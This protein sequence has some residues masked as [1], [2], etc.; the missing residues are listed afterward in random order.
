MDSD[1]MSGCVRSIQQYLK[2]DI[3]WSTHRD[4]KNSLNC[5]APRSVVGKVHREG[6][7]NVPRNFHEKYC[8][9]ILRF[10]SWIKVPETHSNS[11]RQNIWKGFRRDVLENI[12]K[13]H[14]ISIYVFL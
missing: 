5:P 7:V 9:V 11:F 4:F 14:L 6:H 3:A 12:D 8:L 2:R 10:F 1:R 13:G